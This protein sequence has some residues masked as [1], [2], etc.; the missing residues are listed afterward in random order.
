VSEGR[1]VVDLVEGRVSEIRI[2]GT[3]SY[4]ASVL[5]DRIAHQLEGPLEMDRLERG[6]RLLDQDPRIERLAAR[7]LPG[8]ERGEAILDIVILEV[9]P[10][11]LGLMFDNHETPSVGAYAG[12]AA[13]SHANVLGFGDPVA[14]ELT[15]TEGLT[16]LRGGYELPLHPRGPRLLLDGNV[17]LAE[18]V[19]GDFD[20]LDIETTNATFGVGLAQ[21]VFQGVDDRVDVYL[22]FEKRRSKTELLGRGFSFGEDGTQNGRAEVTVLRTAAEWTHRGDS[23]ALSVRSMLSF[24]LDALGATNHSGETP[25][26]VFVSWLGQARGT[27]RLP[28]SGV[29]LRLRGDLQ[30]SDRPLLSLEQFSV[31]GPESVRGVRRNL[32]VRDQG[33][34]AALDVF[35]PLLRSADARPILAVVPFIDVGRAW[36]RDRPTQGKRTISGAGAGISW[37]PHP[38]LEFEVEW[39]QA[40]R[41]VD[42]SGDLQDDG[43]Y[44]RAVGWAF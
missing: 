8:A 31:G 34:A 21:A 30:L 33:F 32:L 12:R 43:V 1:L 23:S 37:F 20:A 2:S 14:L 29:E 11:Q 9:D 15:K 5:R 25:D 24:G 17:T 26:G 3:R 18:L 6:L 38:Q 40:F 27:Y 42:D 16:R 44:L 10:R 22:V 19:D 28:E 13:L 7:L 39:A 41:E 4:R 36:Q 35:V